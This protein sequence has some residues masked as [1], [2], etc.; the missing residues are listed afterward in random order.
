MTNP[1]GK[2]DSE[3]ERAETS[4][5]GY[6]NAEVEP[7][8]F[9]SLTTESVGVDAAQL[10]GISNNVGSSVAE[11]ATQEIPMDIDMPSESTVTVAA[12]SGS[13]NPLETVS[14]QKAVADT[15]N[16][17][18]NELLNEQKGD[19]DRQFETYV[20]ADENNHHTEAL[21]SVNPEGFG[22]GKPT[23]ADGFNQSFSFDPNYGDGGDSGAEEE[24]VA[25]MKELENF[26]KE[27]SWEFK[28][29]KFYGEGLN[30]LK[31]WRTVTRLGGY[32]Q[33]TSCKLWRQ[34]GESFKPPKTCTTVSWSF[35]CFY[36]KALLEYEKHKVRT[37]EL[38]VPISSF[39]EPTT[40]DN[41]GGGNQASGPGRARRDAAARAMQGWHSQRMLGNGEV[42]D[43]VIKDKVPIS[44]IKREKNLKSTAA[45][46]RKK[47]SSMER[48]AKVAHSKLGKPQADL[49]VV[50]VGSP[51][52]WVKINVRTMKD[53]F[54]VYALVPGLLREEVHVQSDPAGRLIISGEPEQPDNPWGVT[55]FKKVITLPSRI[56]PHQTSAVV[57]LH[58]QLFVRAPFEQVDL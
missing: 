1:A 28:P 21:L 51:A 32:D 36:E 19:G 3:R 14:A 47:S 56:D 33:V 24:Q 44:L 18:E 5:A 41:Q 58:G 11:D 27:R 6:I 50:D 46:K 38:H 35:R 48:A 53:C 4:D 16:E 22:G 57:T 43:P 25:F 30:C 2:D 39:P 55:P 17:K 29:P 10:A 12:L 49:M 20:S 7:E 42:G 52:D 23:Q 34:V 8:S 15:K 54:E 40:V 9:P 37:G 26:F 45:F 13:V 31:L